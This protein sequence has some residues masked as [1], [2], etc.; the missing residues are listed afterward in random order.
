MPLE[1]SFFTSPVRKLRPGKA[2][3]LTDEKTPIHVRRPPGPAEEQVELQLRPQQSENKLHTR[4][5]A[6]RES[7]NIWAADHYGRGAERQCFDDVGPS[8]YA[9]VEKKRARSLHH[10]GDGLE[11]VQGGDRRVELAT[12]MVRHNYGLSAV[13]E[14]ESR[15]RGT[16]NPFDQKRQV[17]TRRDP[18]DVLPAQRWIPKV[19]HVCG[20]CGLTRPG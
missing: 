1:P 20:E 3:V 17:G 19:A 18:V 5:S 4:L 11:C 8:S 15:V 9:A 14:G 6:Q 10:C 13:F 16:E 7:P 2:L 12:S